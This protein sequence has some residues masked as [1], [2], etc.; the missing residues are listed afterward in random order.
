MKHKIC[1]VTTSR[2]EYG[3]LRWCIDKINKDPLL[4]LQLIVTGSHLSPEYGNTFSEIVE[5]GYPIAYKVEMLV[6]T[7]T[8][9]GIAKSMG[10]CAI[11]IA[12]A[13]SVLKPELLIILGDRYE[14]LPICSTALV[15][16]I[17]IAHI[18]GG[19]VTEGAIDDNIRNAVSSMASYHFPGVIESAERIER[20]IGRKDTI[21][22]VGET[23]IDNF[24]N[25][26][27]MNRDSISKSLSLD[28]DKRW[29]LLTYHPETKV[30]LEKNLFVAKEIIKSL[31]ELD[32]IHV[33]ITKSNSDFGG[34]QLNEYYND[35][36]RNNPDV[37]TLYSSL[38]QIRYLSL[39]KESF[40]M[41]G[42]SSSGIV[43][44]PFTG[45]PVINIGKRQKGRH[46]CKNIFSCNGDYFSIKA[47]I[48]SIFKIAN[49]PD[50]I[51]ADNYYG[52]GK[53]SERI[54]EILKNNLIKI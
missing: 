35:V 8:Q 10:L 44:A 24:L 32:D 29:I 6:S 52:D 19:D 9:N 37:F 21:F 40:F 1:V 13:F 3:L 51:L 48:H 4:E 38:G 18:S 15:M 7:S 26:Q 39:M 43:E 42:N 31:E 16:N 36:S 30:N 41:I 25:L 50:I 34:S 20:I 27:L 12:D 49:R 28:I 11:S 5:D 33:V 46:L 22:V 14:L 17:P 53:A 45:V 47:Q 23:G 54:I 2:S